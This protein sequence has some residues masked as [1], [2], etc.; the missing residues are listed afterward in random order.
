MTDHK[1]VSHD[2]WL[3]ARKEFLVKEKEFTRLRDA[4]SRER[5]E[6]PWE[7]VEEEYRFETPNGSRTLAEIFDGRSQLLV[8]HFMLGPDWEEGCK[9]CSF[10]ADNYNNIP[11]H[12]NHRDVTFVA[13]SRAPLARIEAYKS[14]MGWSFPWVSSFGSDFNFDYHV[15]LTP[16]EIAAGEAVYN[17]RTLQTTNSEWPGVSV[18]FRDANGAVFHTYSTYE[19]GLDM[20]NGAYHLLDL[21][22]KGRDEDNLPFTMQWVRRHDQYDE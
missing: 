4:L 14:R 3:E 7:R 9:S 2:A 1:I 16:E 21:V 19:R 6:L 5:R 15:S 13:I 11:I 22:P 17:Y 18:F 10:W 20:L 8:Y 12:L